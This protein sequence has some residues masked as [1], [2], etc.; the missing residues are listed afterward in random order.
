MND[1]DMTEV[2][3][4]LKHAYL[5]PISIVLSKL[6]LTVGMDVVSRREHKG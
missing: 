4:C 2:L 6:V 3:D 5:R 1:A